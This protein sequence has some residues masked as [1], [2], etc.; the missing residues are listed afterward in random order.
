VKSD[1]GTEVS[2]TRREDNVWEIKAE[3]YLHQTGMCLVGFILLGIRESLYEKVIMLR[4][5]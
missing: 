2:K 4:A 3:K 5:L 1:Y